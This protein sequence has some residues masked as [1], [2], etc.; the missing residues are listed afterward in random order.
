MRSRLLASLILLALPLGLPAQAPLRPPVPFAA[1]R[2][3]GAMAPGQLA[4]V[5]LAAENAQEMGFSSIAADLYRQLLDA[6][7]SGVGDRLQWR[8]A[9]VTA[10]LE[11]GRVDEAEKALNDFVGVR[12]AAWQLR[13]GLIAAHK[14]QLPAAQAAAAAVKREEL[15]AGD[16]G[17]LFFL[18]S[19]IADAT[20]DNERRN[21]AFEQALGAAVNEMQ[22]TRFQLAREHA[23]LRLGAVTPADVENARRNAERLQGTKAGY[24]FARV[25]AITLN[26]VGRKTEAVGVLQRQLQSLP[27]EERKAVE[28]FRLLLG[29]ITDAAEGVGRNALY[30]LLTTGTDAEKLR[31]ALALLAQAAGTGAE[32]RRKLDEWLATPKP[33]PILE[34]LLLYRAQASL[35]ANDYAGAETDAKRLLEQFPG[36]PLRARALGV[37]TGSAWEQKY[38]RLAADYAAK[39]RAEPAAGAAARAQLGVLVAEAWFRAED[40][41]S[42]ADAYGAVLRDP[43]AGR[44]ERSELM[45]QRMLAET[46]AAERVP[47]GQV[48]ERLKAAGQL[49]DELGRSPDFESELR[50][51]AEYNLARAMQTNQLMAEAYAR[52]TRLL[53]DTKARPDAPELFLRLAWLQARLSYEAGKAADTIKLVDAIQAQSAAADAKVA[54]ALQAEIASTALLLKAQAFF[55]LEHTQPGAAKQGLELLKTLRTTFPKSD[56]AIF[57]YITEADYYEK[58]DQTVLAQQL[59]NQLADD[60]KDNRTYAPLALYRAALLAER[61]GQDSNFKEAIQLIEQLVSRY[62]ESDLVFYARLKQGDLLRK[63]NDFPAAQQAYELLVQNFKQHREVQAAEMALAACHRAQAA[64]DPAHV[65]SAEVIYER[66]L[67][68][69]NATADLRVEAGYNL[70]ASLAQR[71]KPLRAQEIWWGYVV[72]EFLLKADRAAAL[73]AKGR[74]W[75]SRTLLELGALLEQQEKLEEARKAWLLIVDTK[76]PGGALAKAKLARFN[77]PEAKP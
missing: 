65:E 39:T 5:Q 15:D 43:P 38:W 4:A 30:Q 59:L 14:R 72:N 20:G 31:I 48:A 27:P 73:G 36:S 13:A 6:P 10:L 17:W 21:A 51:Q 46:M 19:Q 56:A 62:R 74:Y 3:A 53:E 42:A 2:A 25:Y 45:F 68:L 70:G 16:R 12:G 18:Q 58:N 61:R 71:N 11:S 34:Y 55:V 75:M 24:D 7:A 57:S 35:A 28:D 64:N 63:L 33:H 77:L 37:L 29:L 76:L 41:Q 50:W 32:Y 49:L 69:P 52:V 1:E 47:A 60:Y 54:P 66:L 23:R 8:L 9:L 40:F 67:A 44:K 26:S 22:R